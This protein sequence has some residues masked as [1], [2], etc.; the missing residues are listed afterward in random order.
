MAVLSANEIFE[1]RK[2][3]KTLTGMT[4]TRAWKVQAEDNTSTPADAIA[5]SGIAKIGDAY[6]G[7]EGVKCISLSAKPYEAGFMWIVSA[8]YSI[9]QTTTSD[10]G[11]NGHGHGHPTEQDAQIS[12]D[13]QTYEIARDD[14]YNY[15]TTPTS[16]PLYPADGFT[17]ANITA[18]TPTDVRGH[19]SKQILNSC[20][21]RYADPAIIQKFNLV[22]NIDINEDDDQYDPDIA[23]KYLGT[24]NAKKITIASIEIPPLCGK[25]KKFG[26]QMAFD[27]D[28]KL[29]W[30]VHYE[31]EIDKETH[32]KRVL[33]SGLYE[34]ITVTD[35]FGNHLAY[36]PIKDTEG[37]AI[38][39][40]VPLNGGGSKAMIGEEWYFTHI[41]DWMEDWTP[42]G[43][44]VN[45]NGSRK[46]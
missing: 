2:A 36:T 42:L 27:S 19:P 40:P 16:D 14:S 44:P 29:Y 39:E 21:Q 10:G 18:I 26:G 17:P 4:A 30:K 7:L 45:K 25:M 31:I 9:S 46:I 22:I 37:N 6:P 15:T 11:G 43:L 41:V 24:L 32:A 8:E 28:G 13:H 5:G 12:F 3:Q 38:T 1:E 35:S 34:A 33:D 20:R 23:T